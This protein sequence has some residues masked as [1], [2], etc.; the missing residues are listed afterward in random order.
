VVVASSA[1]SEPSVA[2]RI[3][4]GKMNLNLDRFVLCPLYHH[5]PLP[6]IRAVSS[7]TLH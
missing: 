7:E 5:A 2:R 4:V 3:F 1:S 6:A